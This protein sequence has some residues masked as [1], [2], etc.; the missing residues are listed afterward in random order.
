ML[1]Y[2]WCAL[3]MCYV[4]S[5]LYNTALGYSKQYSRYKHDHS[6]SLDHAQVTVFVESIEFF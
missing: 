3:F 6:Q 5:C 2:S 1:R 4:T